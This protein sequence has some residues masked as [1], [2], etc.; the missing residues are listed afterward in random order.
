[1]TTAQKVEEHALLRKYAALIKTYSDAV[2][3]N[4][5]LKAA[6]DKY[7]EDETLKGNL[8]P[9][10]DAGM[11]IVPVEPTY[12]ML[13]KGCEKCFGR[14]D[15]TLYAMMKVAYKAMLAASK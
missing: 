2:A 11:A 4:A 9:P 6:M 10:A 8:H 12:H 3:E 1:M 15:K 5:R 13:V 14:A 7:S